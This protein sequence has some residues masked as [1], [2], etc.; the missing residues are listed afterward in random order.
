MFAK[1]KICDNQSSRPSSD[2]PS[3]LGHFRRTRTLFRLHTHHPL[4]KRL[5][6]LHPT[7][8]L[9]ENS[10]HLMMERPEFL[11]LPLDNQSVE[12]I[13]GHCQLEG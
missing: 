6:L 13:L 7:G 12:L 9:T 3:I 1:I 10:I 8:L 5:K 11:E 4:E 2:Q